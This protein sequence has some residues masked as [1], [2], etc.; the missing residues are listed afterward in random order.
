MGYFVDS[1]PM[2]ASVFNGEFELCA[3]FFD[4]KRRP[5][6]LETCGGRIKKAASIC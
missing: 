2:N 1:I 4:E 5:F 6:W 3:G